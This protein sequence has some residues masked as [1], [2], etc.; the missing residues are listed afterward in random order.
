MAPQGQREREITRHGNERGKN[1]SDREKPSSYCSSNQPDALWL[2]CQ[3][4][5]LGKS[6]VTQKVPQAHKRASAMRRQ[7]ARTLHGHI[8][9]KHQLQWRRRLQ[10]WLQLV[11]LF[12]SRCLSLIIS[13][14]APTAGLLLLLSCIQRNQTTVWRSPIEQSMHATCN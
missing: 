6:P 11:G 9:I 5:P 13:V 14:T 2:L 12:F 8:G 4:F 1:M 7:Q 10:Y 3:M